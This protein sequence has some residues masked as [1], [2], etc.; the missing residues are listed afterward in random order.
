MS[1]R[2]DRPGSRV[3]DER[4]GNVS[5]VLWFLGYN[6]VIAVP[7][8]LLGVSFT[9]QLLPAVR[10]GQAL[11]VGLVAWV[12]PLGY[13][14]YRRQ[15]LNDEFVTLV[16]Q[17]RAQRARRLDAEGDTYAVIGLG[18]SADPVRGTNTKRVAH[19]F[20]LGDDHVRVIGGPVLTFKTRAVTQLDRDEAFAWDDVA[21]VEG[22]GDTLVLN[23]AGSRYQYPAEQRPAELLTRLR[24]RAG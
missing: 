3:T 4:L 9:L 11:L 17:R 8:L 2:A 7:V 13:V 5:R 20:V 24:R 18:G 6:G 23:V 15:S 21:S 19:Y 14:R 22:S 1:E 16:E 12:V 10:P